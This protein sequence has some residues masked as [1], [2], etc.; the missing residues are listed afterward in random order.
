[1][2]VLY[3]KRQY[4]TVYYIYKKYKKNT[5]YTIYKKFKF[6]EISNKSQILKVSDCK[7]QIR[8]L[9]NCRY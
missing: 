5:N 9:Y 8:A 2:L 7:R 4:T 6:C 3:S 1:M